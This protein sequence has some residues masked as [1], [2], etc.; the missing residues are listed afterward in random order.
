VERSSHVPVGGVQQSHG[1]QIRGGRR[2][3]LVA[4]PFSHSNVCSN[5]LFVGDASKDRCSPRRRTT[6]P[7]DRPNRPWSPT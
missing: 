5:V 2:L 6:H 3:F 7:P 1:A 4:T